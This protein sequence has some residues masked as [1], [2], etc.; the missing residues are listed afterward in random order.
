M[1]FVR[2]ATEPFAVMAPHLRKLPRQAR[3]RERLESLLDAAADILEARGIEGLTITAVAVRTE[4]PPGSVYEYVADTRDLV[5]AVA[6]RGLDALHR[7]L[8]EIL[9]LVRSPGT[10][11][12]ALRAALQLFLVRLRETPGLL[13]ALAAL[14]ADPR[15]GRIHVDDSRRNAAL[16]HDSLA[17]VVPPADR[18]R[19]HA[20]CLLLFQLAAGAARLVHAVDGDD[21]ASLTRE[22]EAILL[23][24]VPV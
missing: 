19:L 2:P 24:L 8:V 3:S 7:E 22:L 21:A 20:R 13:E 1:P 9:A 17:S 16:L 4:L 5:A 10:A 6:L 18:L 11:R 14:D 12:E 15:L 23:S